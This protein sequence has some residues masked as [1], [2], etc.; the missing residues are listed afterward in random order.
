MPDAAH[1]ESF[2][3][4]VSS[5]KGFSGNTLSAY[6]IDLAQF[7]DYLSSGQGAGI[8]PAAA[9]TDV[10]RDH[11]MAFVLYLKERGY[12]T[13]TVARKLAAV[14]SFFK[15]LISERVISTSP[16]EEMVSPHVDRALPHTVPSS[17]LDRL[18]AR[19]NATGDSPEV[20]RDRAM[21]QLIYS[22]GM[23]VGELVGLNVDDL[24]L[25]EGTVSAAAGRG[26]SRRIVINSPVALQALGDYL[27]KGR[28]VLVRAHERGANLAAEEQTGE[29]LFLNH[30]GQ[31]LT[32]QGFWLIL[33]AYA[34][35]AG[36][37]NIT[38]H[39]LRHSFAAQ[40]LQ[41]GAD[42]RDL[43]KILGHANIST[44]QIY[45]RMGESGKRQPRR[46][47]ARRG[48]RKAG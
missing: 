1:I 46:G 22:T 42:I 21:L 14:R 47:A 6:R 23:R 7:N 9:W 2:L 18:M 15:Y 25:T 29:P 43:Q 3:R 31:R 39:I 20:L 32:R 24:D 44:T 36:L 34:R 4:T 33:K 30:R 12:A 19:L 40:K 5:Q 8:A 11:L 45:A 28:P 41:G 27:D 26:K 48:Q 10:T 35:S 13:T 37:G 17:E 38:P 16:T